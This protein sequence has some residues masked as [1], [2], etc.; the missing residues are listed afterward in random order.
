MN[1]RQKIAMALCAFYLISVIGV[2]LSLHFCGG[3]LSGIDFTKLAHCKGCK[4]EKTAQADNCCKNTAVEAKIKDS[5]ESGVK[6]NMPKDYG[7][8]LFFT[9][10]LSDIAERIFPRLFGKVDREVPPLSARIPLYAYH[11]VFRN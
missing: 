3:K 4:T 11:C 2:A 8:R 5:H 1:F 9:P 10:L 7:L 6:V